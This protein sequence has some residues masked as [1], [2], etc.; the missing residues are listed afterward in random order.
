MRRRSPKL[1]AD[2]VTSLVGTVAPLTVL[3]RVQVIWKAAVGEAIAREAEPVF[4]RAGILSI[5]CRS[6]VW[7]NEIELL[8]NQLITK[9]NEELKSQSVSSL[10][11]KIDPDRF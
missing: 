10:R 4:E 8:S 6:S 5:A 1:I 11:I 2:S 7:A 9:I 3:A